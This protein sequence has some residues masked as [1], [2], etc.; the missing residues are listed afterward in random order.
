MH[1]SK[2]QGSIDTYNAAHDAAGATLRRFAD[3]VLLPLFPLDLVL[4]LRFARTPARPRARPPS[5]VVCG[6]ALELAAAAG[7][8]VH[9][10]DAD[11]MPRYDA[12]GV[13][14]WYPANPT[15]DMS[16]IQ[17]YDRAAVLAHDVLHELAHFALCTPARRALPN[18]GLGSNADTC[19]T[20]VVPGPAPDWEEIVVCAY[21]L[22]VAWAQ[23]LGDAYIEKMCRYSGEPAELLV[24]TAMLIEDGYITPDGVPTGKLRADGEPLRMANRAHGTVMFRDGV[25]PLLEQQYDTPERLALLQSAGLA[26]EVAAEQA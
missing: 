19:D 14:I 21:T 2:L 5:D 8:R 1:A 22:F 23:G 11:N 6:R 24:Q 9:I 16:L 20:E 12:T 3:D 15:D 4:S 18:Y 26:R 7:L 10:A 17:P 25:I 13:H